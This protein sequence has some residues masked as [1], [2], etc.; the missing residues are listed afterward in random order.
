[1]RATLLYFFVFWLSIGVLPAQS[2]ELSIVDVVQLRS[3]EKIR[4]QLAAPVFGRTL[5]VA[6]WEPTEGD[7]KRINVEQERATDST[8]LPTLALT[9]PPPTYTEPGRTWLHHFSF[10]GL[11]GVEAAS[12]FG[13]PTSSRIVGL[14]ANYTLV[15]SF[16]ALRAG[17][18]VD[19]A[20]LN[21]ERGEI[22]VAVTGLIEYVINRG[23]A[24]KVNYYVRLLAGPSLPVGSPGVDQ[25]ITSRDVGLV[26]NPSVG[27]E[28]R[29]GG[30]DHKNIFLDVGYRFLDA[31]FT[32]TTANQVVRERSVAYRRLSF[33]SGFRF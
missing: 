27:V 33:R 18:G 2:S 11:F 32:L 25:E 4:G 29:S 13:E 23:D 14:G 3:G 24:R 10:G 6:A 20:L 15:K 22:S 31:Q 17:G 9:T 12:N 1:M 26:L 19:Y 28:F 16:G 21:Y 7:L 5:I 30:N 8:D